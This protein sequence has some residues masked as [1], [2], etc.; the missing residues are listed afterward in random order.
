[1]SVLFEDEARL[2]KGRSL[3]EAATQPLDRKDQRGQADP[4]RRRTRT[5][6]VRSFLQVLQAN[7][8]EHALP[9]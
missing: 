5:V 6:K 8:D 3:R 2:C 9:I 1:M 4:P 7:A